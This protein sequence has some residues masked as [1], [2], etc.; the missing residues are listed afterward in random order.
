MVAHLSRSPGAIHRRFISLHRR[1]LRPCHFAG[2]PAQKSGCPRGKTRRRALNRSAR[3]VVRSFS[4]WF[5][6]GK[7]RGH[8]NTQCVR[9]FVDTFEGYVS[10]TS[11]HIGNIR[12]M[13][14]RSFGQ[15]FL[16]QPQLFSLPLDRI[17][18]CFFYINLRHSFLSSFVIALKS[19][20]S[21]QQ[22]LSDH[23]Q[24]DCTTL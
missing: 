10:R 11:F 3:H 21:T 8:C 5:F 12:A 4:I 16:R 22:T 24:T 13:Q 1:V 9:E 14:S 7:Q 6:V 17:S 18:K 20:Q 23:T 19:Y 2:S 15:F